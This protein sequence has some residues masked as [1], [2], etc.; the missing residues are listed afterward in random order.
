[1]CAIKKQSHAQRFGALNS[2]KPHLTANVIIVLELSGERFVGGGIPF[3]SGDAEFD[4][5]AEPGT[6]LVGIFHGEIG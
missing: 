4:G 1:L 5:L 2:H 3:K 6:D